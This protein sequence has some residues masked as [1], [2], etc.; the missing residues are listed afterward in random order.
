MLS[1][2][3]SQWLVQDRRWRDKVR[4]TKTDGFSSQPAN[5]PFARGPISSNTQLISASFSSYSN[6]TCSFRAAEESRWRSSMVLHHRPPAVPS[7][8]LQ[9]ASS[10]ST[11]PEVLGACSAQRLCVQLWVMHGII[12]PKRHTQPCYVPVQKASRAVSGKENQPRWRRQTCFGFF[13]VS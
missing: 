8:P 6:T 10:G 7:S 13:H 5:D 4:D 12:L 1:L 2:T 11:M 9:A 3:V